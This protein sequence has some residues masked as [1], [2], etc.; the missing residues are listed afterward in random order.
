MNGVQFL[1]LIGDARAF[2]QSASLIEREI[3]RI[4][5]RGGDLSPVGG[6]SGWPSHT[7]WE[8]LKTASHF[9]CRISRK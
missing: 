2:R 5:V 1:R 9:N 8:S 4:G 7:V 3:A 6:A